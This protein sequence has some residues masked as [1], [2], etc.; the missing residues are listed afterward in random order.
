MGAVMVIHCIPRHSQF[1]TGHGTRIFK[2][3]VVEVEVKIH[4]IFLILIETFFLHV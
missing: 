1:L 3:F 4:D 2:V